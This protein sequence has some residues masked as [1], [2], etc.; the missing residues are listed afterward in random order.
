MTENRN[1]EGA[2]QGASGDRVTPYLDL[3]L[4]RGTKDTARAGLFLSV[5]ALIFVMVL[6]AYG[7]NA[8]KD[9]QSR[10]DVLGAFD[11]RLGGVETRL[12]SLEGLPEAVRQAYVSGAVKEMAARVAALSGE[13]QDEARKAK[14][15]EIGRLLGELGADR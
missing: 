15:A 14:L 13:V 5:V 10:L 3:S 12:A 6:F 9:T 2:G 8:L 4:L 7:Y 1:P 11:Q